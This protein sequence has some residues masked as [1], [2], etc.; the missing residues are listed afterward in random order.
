MTEKALTKAQADQVAV[1]AFLKKASAVAPLQAGR[2]GRLMFAIDATASRQPT[3]DMASQV[4]GEMFQATRELGGLD[5]QVV[6]FR[7]FG[8]FRASPWLAS[9][10][11]VARRMTKVSCLAGRT[12]IAKV[13][14][15]ALNETAKRK[16][17]G[18][19]YIGDSLEEDI[20]ELGELAGKLGVVGLPVFPFHE[21]D[22]PVASFGFSQLAK[23]S[24]GVYCPF[25]PGAAD[26][27]KA[28][29]G[30]VA[31]YASAGREA[32]LRLSTRGSGSGNADIKRL[33]DGLKRGGA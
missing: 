7:G 22:D 32:L 8:E 20:D 5:L 33:V 6:F 1:D 2:P 16:V 24:G 12:Q 9:G 29:L 31:V 19:I 10:E 15:H 17:N 14:Q 18:L 23:L 13:L 27:L 28:L 4:Q 21:G 25:E 30:A 26:R 3:W 11:D